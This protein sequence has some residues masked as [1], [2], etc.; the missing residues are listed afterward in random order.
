MSDDQ[1]FRNSRHIETVRNYINVIVKEL[2]LRG[3][4]HDQTKFDSPEREI[5]DL[6]GEKMRSVPYGSDE[7]MEILKEIK[8]ATDY[9]NKYNRHHPE[10]FDGDIR[11]MNLIDLIEML[12][13]WKAASMRRSDGSIERSIDINKARFDYSNE[14]SQI[15]HN[16]AKFINENEPFHKANES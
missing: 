10:F 14:L 2:L 16:T 13:D 4:K 3:E 15:F 6:Y 5:F 9:H 12:C 1:R 7:Y 11:K 8:V